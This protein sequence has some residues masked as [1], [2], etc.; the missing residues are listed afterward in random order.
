[1]KNSVNLKSKKNI[2]TTLTKLPFE[3]L[4]TGA[5]LSPETFMKGLAA[6]L[7][8]GITR[9][10]NRF[11]NALA[12][13]NWYLFPQAE[14][15]WSEEIAVVTGG[16]SGI[17]KALALSLS[18]KD[19]RV[20]ALDIQDAPEEFAHDSRITF[21]RCDVS[22]A[23]AIAD[24]AAA[25][26][27]KLGNPS[28]LINNAGISGG[29]TI[30]KTSPEYLDAIFKVNVLSHWHTVRALAPHM[31]GANKGHIVTLASVSSFITNSANADYTAT[32]CA[33]LAFHEG[34]TQELKVWYKC[35]GVVTSV[36]HPS[37][38]R[39]PMIEGDVL[40]SGQG[41]ATLEGMLRPEEVAERILQQILSGRGA[42]IIIPEAVSPVSW[43]KGLPNWA[44]EGLRDLFGGMTAKYSGSV[45]EK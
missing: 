38:V 2:V 26:Q 20:A 16:C 31:I 28:I 12:C 37:F 1:M 33:S 4:V 35:P 19:I 22:S 17:G 10:S 13:N 36:V 34:L 27:R 41:E 29:H 39:T 40:R 23:A 30:F 44:Q 42:Q 3:P 9:R 45:I 8:L 18:A 7:T 15:N 6:L 25:I 21:F 24:T 5:Y 32:K 11:L 14:W 43:V